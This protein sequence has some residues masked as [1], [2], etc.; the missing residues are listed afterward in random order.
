M[1]KVI[2]HDALAELSIKWPADAGIGPELNAVIT[3]ASSPIGAAIATAIASTGAAV[4][5]VGRNAERL[6]AIAE[7][8]R[9]TARSALVIK[10]DLTE[11]SAVENLTRRLKKEFSPL[12]VLVHCAGAF[13]TGSIATT[14]ITQLDALY[15]ANVRMPFELTQ[16]LLPLLKSRS[17]QI[18]FINSSQGLTARANTGAYAATQHALKALADSLRQE[19]NADSVRVVSLF[20][21]RTATARMKALY[22]TEGRKYEPELLLQAEDIAQVVMASL[23]LP[24]TAEITDVAIRPFRKSY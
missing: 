11:E 12:D 2:R 10:S 9:K 23:Q 24:R 15:R 1:S 20:L 16:A 22:Q 6:Q 14:P 4:C 21:G 13:T 3:G 17:G 18:V 7:R 8:V 19:I 5:L